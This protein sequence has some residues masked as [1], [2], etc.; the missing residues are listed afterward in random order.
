MKDPLKE[1][2]K[3]L[4]EL[5]KYHRYSQESF[6][7]ACGLDRTYIGGVERG[8]RNISLINLTKIARALNTSTSELLDYNRPLSN[9]GLTYRE[10]VER[11]DIEEALQKEREL[12]ESIKDRDP[13][14]LEKL[15]TAL[16]EKKEYKWVGSPD[17]K[18]EKIL[19][20]AT[21]GVLDDINL[22]DSDDVN[23]EVLD[24]GENYKIIKLTGS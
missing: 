6:A 4:R 1:F 17:S 19:L 8:E 9:T 5:R 3:R 14:L 15:K 11:A 24:E 22:E 23:V 12:L 10:E 20:D 2:G 16:W 21:L 7:L 18:E 13:S